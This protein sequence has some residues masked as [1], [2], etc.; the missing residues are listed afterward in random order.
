M[1]NQFQR[2]FVTAFRA[3]QRVLPEAFDEA[4]RKRFRRQNTIAY[5]VVGH[6][7]RQYIVELF[8]AF[9]ISHIAVEAVISDSLKTLRQKQNEYWLTES[10]LDA[11]KFDFLSNQ[12][13]KTNLE[14]LKS[15]VSLGKMN[16]FKA[17]EYLISL[18]KKTD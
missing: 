2:H 12:N 15:E 8:S 11:L 1:I 5:L 6:I 9:F 4:L 3:D 16:P 7:G 14:R 13:V 18:Y 17:S 10:L